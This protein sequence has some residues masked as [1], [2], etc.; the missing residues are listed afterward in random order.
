MRCFLW[1]FVSLLLLATDSSFAEFYKYRDENGVV[2]FTDNILEVPKSQQ[3]K[4]ETYPE[5]QFLEEAGEAA[6]VE[7]MDDIEKRLRAQKERLDKEY[8]ELSAERQQL[9]EAAKIA[10]TKTEND[11]FEKEIEDFNLRLQQYEEQRLLFKE[12]VDAFNEARDAQLK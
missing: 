8:S 11:A 9:E 1:I 2:R 5:I 7:S 10:R 6:E 12:K 4:V 3:I